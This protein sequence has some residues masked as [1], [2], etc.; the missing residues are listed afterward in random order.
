MIR[1]EEAWRRIAEQLE[2]LPSE[3]VP[4][5]QAVGRVMAT[6]LPATVDVPAHDVSAMDGFAVQGEIQVGQVLPIQ[7]TVAAGDPP[8]VRL[9]PRTALRIMTGAPVPERADRIVP[10]EQTAAHGD[11]AIRFLAGVAVDAHIRHQA[12]VTKRGTPLLAAPTP[13]T[14]GAISLL[15]THG[16]EE[17]IVHRR[18]RVA[19]LA[20]GDEVVAPQEKPRPGQLRDSHTDFLLAAGHGLGLA[21]E[22]LGIARDQPDDLRQKIERGLTSDVLLIG[23]G[24]S[25]GEFDFVE[26]VLEDLGCD[27]LF[28]AVAVQP[29]KPLVVARHAGG[30]VFGLPGNPASVMVG[31]WLFVRPVLRRLQGIPDRYWSGALTA[32]LAAPLPGAKGRDRFLMAEIQFESGRVLVTPQIARGSH[33]LTAFAR[34][35]ALVRIPAGASPAVA[36][37]VCEILPL[38]D[39]PDWGADVQSR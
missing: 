1:P 33:D 2:P 30:W 34:G 35:S 6:S 28:D 13:L 19:I 7:G 39:W 22:P 9:E 37:Q 21:F 25:M 32:E 4:R 29:G 16:Y 20:T 18:P 17:V 8:G 26:D 12:E 5:R 27:K 3:S 10:V 15:A 24:V 38:A 23:G 36:G 14:A 31:F 11:S